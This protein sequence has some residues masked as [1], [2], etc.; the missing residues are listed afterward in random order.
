VVVNGLQTG[1]HAREPG[2]AH[3]LFAAGEVVGVDV[4]PDDRQVAR[5][6][7]VGAAHQRRAR[8]D[9]DVEQAGTPR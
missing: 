8:A 6:D 4:D 5:A 3:R 1:R 7:H 2:A 9:A